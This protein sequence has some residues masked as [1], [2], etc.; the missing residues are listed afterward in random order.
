MFLFWFWHVILCYMAVRHVLLISN[1]VRKHA[2][3]SSLIWIITKGADRT[4]K[5]LQV[6]KFWDWR[7]N[8]KCRRI[9]AFSK[10]TKK[11]RGLR[12]GYVF[13]RVLFNLYSEIILKIPWILS[14]FIIGWRNLNNIKYAD[15]IVLMAN[16]ERKL[17]GSE[18]MEGERA[19]LIVRQQ[20]LWLPTNE[21][22]QDANYELEIP[23]Y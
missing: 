8:Y 5:G 11:E 18:G 9:H 21:K 3:N 4:N 17:K 6:K 22:V 19:V 2:F 1:A 15:E 13:W 20:K 7:G 10:Y 23:K 16:T 12:Q 14:G